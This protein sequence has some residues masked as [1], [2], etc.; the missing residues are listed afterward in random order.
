MGNR[1]ILEKMGLLEKDCKCP[2]SGEGVSGKP[3]AATWPYFV[4]VD[5][6]LGQRHSTTT[7]VLI[8]SI[9]EETPGPSTAVDDQEES[10]LQPLNRKRRR[11]DALLQLIKEDMQLQR[12]AEES[13]G[14]QREWKGSSLY[15]RD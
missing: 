14:K 15:W 13:T 9:L 5:E 4:L 7:P 2:G 12:D 1:T 11:D 6:E 3:T 10:Q 8:A